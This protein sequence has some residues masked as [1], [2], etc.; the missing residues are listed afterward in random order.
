LTSEPS[1]PYTPKPIKVKIE[2]T[3]DSGTKYAF[4]IEGSSK[5]NITK[6]IEFAQAT[7]AT[8][9][10]LEQDLAGTNFAKLYGLLETRFHFGAFTSTDVLHAYEQDFNTPT[11]LGVI[12]TYLSRLTK[13]GMLTRLRHGSGWTYRL[14]RS[15]A[16]RRE[17]IT[18]STPDELLRSGQIPP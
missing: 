8:T 10:P 5:E 3:D 16:Q 11:S 13:R 18:Q 1:T 6:L 9:T 12:A 2:F 4:N 14:A 17:M 15:E 7:S